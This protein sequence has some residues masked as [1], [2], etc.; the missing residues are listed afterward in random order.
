MNNVLLVQHGSKKT[1]TNPIANGATNNSTISAVPQMTSNTA[2]SGQCSSDDSAYPY[3]YAF[4]RNNS[5]Y[6]QSDAL[7]AYIQYKFA[8]AKPINKYSIVCIDETYYNTGWI[9]YGSN[10]GVSMTT[11]DSR[12]GQTF[13]SPTDERFFYFNNATPYLYYRLLILDVANGGT[14]GIIRELKLIECQ[15][16]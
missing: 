12:T 8:A 4:D 16:S 10:D 2:P 15:Y 7:P 13:A 9:L 3:Y 14:G 6:W 1:V 5:T 11:L